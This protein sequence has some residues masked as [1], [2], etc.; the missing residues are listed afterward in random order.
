MAAFLVG[1]GADVEAADDKGVSACLVAAATG[2]S[3]ASLSM[4]HRCFKQGTG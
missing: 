2:A 1:R 4:A 3:S